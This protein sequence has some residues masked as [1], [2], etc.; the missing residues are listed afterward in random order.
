MYLS[1]MYKAKKDF[2]QLWSGKK[3]SAILSGLL[4]EIRKKL[5]ISVETDLMRHLIIFYPKATHNLKTISL[6]DTEVD[7]TYPCNYF[8]PLRPIF[9]YHYDIAVLKIKVLS[10]MVTTPASIIRTFPENR[11]MK[12]K[13]KLYSLTN[14]SQW[15]DR[16][17]AALWCL[18]QP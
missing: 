8:Y 7:L 14:D 11:E 2:P 4:F 10:Y 9:A 3:K 16:A 6:L 17:V 18:W 13:V 12:Q 5:N 1:Q 15:C